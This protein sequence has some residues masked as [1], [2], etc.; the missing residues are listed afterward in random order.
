[1]P[2]SPETRRRVV[3]HIRAKG[4]RITDQ[5]LAI[6]DAA[7]STQ[8]HYT[9]EQLL[10]VA[11]KVNRDVSRATVYRTLPLIV[12]TGL[13]HE[14]DLG[15]DQKI[16]DPNYAEHPNHNH[17]ICLDCDKIFEFEDE[18]LDAKE[19]EISQK[20]GFEPAS[21]HIRIEAN[22]QKLKKNGVCQNVCVP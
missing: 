11:R 2:I 1:V 3:E 10:A 22:C 14:L 17:L 20:L 12:E 21:K 19:N 7:F 5:R 6:I 9:A 8:D 4:L 15:R 16:Y 13:L 18:H